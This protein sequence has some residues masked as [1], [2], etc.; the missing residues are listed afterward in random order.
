MSRSLRRPRRLLAAGTAAIVV[1][2]GCGGPPPSAAPD[3]S[4][5]PAPTQEAAFPTAPPTSGPFEP[6]AYPAD[7][8]APCDQPESDDPAYGPYEGS[9]QRIR[10][11]DP[12]TVRFELCD[13]D[14]AFLAKIASPA[15]AIDDTAWLE[16]RLDPAADPPRI[17][18]EVNGTGPFR[19]DRWDGSGD[20]AL[21]RSTT[22]WGDRSRTGTV[23]FVAEADDGRR[24]AKL[25]EGSVDAVDVVAPRDM[26]AVNAN[27]E[28]TLVPRRGLNIAYIGFDNRFAPFDNETVRN[29]IA[30]GIDRAAIVAGAFPPGTEVASHFL[31]CAI[32]FGCEGPGWPAPD[33]ELARDLLADVGFPEGF[34]STISYSEEPRDYLPDPT[35]TATALQAQLRDQL[36]IATTLKPMPFADLTA[37]ADAGRLGGFYLL[38]ARARYPDPSLLLDSHFGPNASLQF[39]KRF[40]DIA[41]WLDRGRG[42]VD[43]AARAKGYG[44]VNQL[45]RKHVPMIPLAH[46]GSAAAFRTDVSGQ[47]ASATAT[48][49]F[50][51]VAP[52]DR[53]QFV[54]M[55]RTKPGSLFCAD[56]TDESALRVCAQTSESLYR[57]DVPEPA[58]TPALAESCVPNAD[59]NVWTCTI[60]S[61]ITF[62]D[63]TALDAN[64][65]VLSYAVRWDAAHPLHRGREG[66]FRAFQDRFGGL[67]HP[68]ATAASR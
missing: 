33:P 2:A 49:R 29:A 3:A 11:T 26:E 12:L 66:A 17:L 59:L 24:L 7:A 65:V 56:E 41:R 21:S 19:L 58:V 37:A 39:G 30:V 55:Q 68:P 61:G 1:L 13:S 8:A 53:T 52:G 40:V 43:A 16:S 9:I 63:G 51:A 31:P 6:M 4:R 28:L 34:T 62:H 60:R 54:Y 47:Q 44:G 42:S 14:P 46:V 48:D 64:D 38:G 36:G 45:I 10:A 22:Y 18:T 25:R 5:L 57:H 20:I 67:L 15:L 50:A 32:P 27:P 23:I 35:A